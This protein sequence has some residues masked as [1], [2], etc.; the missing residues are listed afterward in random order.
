[1][2]P[3]LPFL[4]PAPMATGEPPKALPKPW[5]EKA[6]LSFVSTSGNA[7]GGTLG[8]T[9]EFLYKWKRAQLQA[10]LSAV[11]I[12]A[13][14][15][16]RSATGA[17]LSDFAITETKTTRTTSENYVAGLRY[18]HRITEHFFWFAGGGWERNVPAGLNS[19]VKG[20]AGFGRIWIHG[21]VTRFRTDFGLGQTHEIPVFRPKGFQDSFGTWNLNAKLEQKTGAT[22]GFVSELAFTGSFQDSADHITV[23]KNALSSNLNNHFAL[24]IGLDFNYR[25][26]PA[27]IGVD[28]VQAGSNPP[29]IL[30]QVPFLLKK[31]DSVFTTS[32]VLTF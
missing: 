28:L 10:N 17:S 5:S 11:R 6:S 27:S 14:S 18:D 1:M 3:F 7:E 22:S 21:P 25:N 29:V 26:R 32:L 23:W 19:R 20:S 9:N 4:L 15:V 8:F 30:G 13:T 16:T 12:N 2:L 24:K 31:L